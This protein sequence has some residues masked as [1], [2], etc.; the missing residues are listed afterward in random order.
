MIWPSVSASRPE[1]FAAAPPAKARERAMVSV[2]KLERLAAPPVKA[3]EK[4][5]R[6]AGL[7]VSA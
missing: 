5:L 2:S 6:M 1:Q 3:R 7:V 4:V